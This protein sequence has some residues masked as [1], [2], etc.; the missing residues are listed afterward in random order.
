MR[1]W[2]VG[3]ALVCPASKTKFITH[4]ETRDRCGAR[5]ELWIED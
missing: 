1:W 4:V 3:L 2:L 5:D